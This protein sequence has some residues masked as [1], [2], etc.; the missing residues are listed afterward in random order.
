MQSS[1][2]SG[3]LLAVAA[4]AIFATHDALIKHL[5]GSYAVFQILFFSVMFGFPPIA[6]SMSA[7]R[8]IDNFRPHHPWWLA[9]RTLCNLIGMVCAFYAF[10]TLP[11]AQAYAILFATPLL[12]TALSVPMLGEVVR[13][14]RWIAILFGLLGVLVVLRPGATDLELGHAAALVAAIVSALGSIIV[15]KIGPDERS[16]VLVLYPLVLSMVA[17]GALLPFVY[18]PMPLPD[19]GLTAVIGFMAFVAQFAIIGAYKRATA[20]LIAPMQYSQ[21]LWAAL[22]GALFFDEFP[23][24]WVAVGATIIIASGI[25]LVLRESKE[26]ISGEK[27]V[28]RTPN[29]RN[30][31]G[32]S[33]DPKGKKRGG[34][35]R[36]YRS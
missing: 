7:S 28:L 8:A 9:A 32:F 3:V 20:A 29:Y 17:M 36:R 13:L 24:I 6:L 33:M 15:R 11:L 22:Y 10:T 35:F 18:V 23:D 5:G 21:I 4:F 25:Y 26:D 27:P 31:S 16:T 12:I 34:I 2:R 1:Q 30:F 14:R 19:L